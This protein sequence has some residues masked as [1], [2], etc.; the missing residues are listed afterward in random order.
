MNEDTSTT[1]TVEDTVVETTPET[2]EVEPSNQKEVEPQ[3][4]TP[5]K[6]ADKYTSPEDL[7]KAYL[8]AQRKLTEQS[9]KLK[10][11]EAPKYTPDQQEIAKQIQSLGFMT[12]EQFEQQQAVQVQQAKDNA[13]IKQLNI[14]DAQA[15]VLKR[16][17]L[18]PENITKSMTELWN[19]LNSMVGGKVVSRKT[20]IKPKNG[21]RDGFTPLPNSVVAKLS[22]EKYE[23]YWK[24][25]SVHMANK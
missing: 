17:A 22:P 12:K 23:Q 15:A 11:Y 2:V 3:N 1:E 10:E 6:Y 9:T 7:E 20:K 5:R 16:Y 21:S 19:E 18:H 13:E 24:E 8:E 4:E 14:D 25:Y